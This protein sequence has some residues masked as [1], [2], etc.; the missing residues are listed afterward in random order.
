MTEGQLQAGTLQNTILSLPIQISDLAGNN[1]K[2][3]VVNMFK[4]L[5][6]AKLKG[7]NDGMITVSHQIENIN[8]ER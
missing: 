1:F 8:K 3:Y 7:L 5:K 6:D 4:E 2:A